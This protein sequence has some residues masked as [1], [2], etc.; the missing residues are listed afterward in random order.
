MMARVSAAEYPMLDPRELGQ[1]C[2]SVQASPVC[3]TG[4]EIMRSADDDSHGHTRYLGSANVL[5]NM[6]HLDRRNVEQSDRSSRSWTD[7]S[8]GPWLRFDAR[9]RMDSVADGRAR[10]PYFDSLPVRIPSTSDGRTPM[11][12]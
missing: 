11:G 8:G 6:H 1:R 3:T 9:M 4:I 2:R 5:V 12:R 7:A 10:L